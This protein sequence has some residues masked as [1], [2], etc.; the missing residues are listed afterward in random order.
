[1]NLDNKKD[2]IHQQLTVMAT[3]T[4]GIKV[5]GPELIGRAFEYFAISRYLYK[6]LRRDYQLPSVS[7]LTRITSK[8]SKESENTFLKSVFNSVDDNQKLSVILHD[9]IYVKKMLLC[10]G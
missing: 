4:V 5:Y 1:M 3:Q 9:E 6:H 2:L 8:V 7:T 10:H